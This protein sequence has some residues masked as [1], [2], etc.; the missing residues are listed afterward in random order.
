MEENMM[1]FGQM[2][3]DGN[4]EN[5]KILFLSIIGEIEGH[6]L[7]SENI[8]TT[9]YEHLLPILARAQDDKN[10]EGII[11]LIN[12]VGG[13]CSCGLALAEMIASMTKP[14]VSLI[15]GDSHSIGFP[16]SVAADYTFIAPTAT[17]ILHPVRLT[18]T[19]IG[20]PQTFDYFRLMQDRIINFLTEHT[21]ASKNV[22]EEMMLH[23][24]IMT[25]DLGTILLGEEAVKK[26]LV[27]ETG[28]IG[29]AL[30]W[31]HREIENRKKQLFK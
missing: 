9:K 12:S 15:I 24:G 28:G 30:E 29:D 8:K 23:Q 17:V 27:D 2:L 6:H 10:I 19:I 25:K 14:V 1:E 7:S 22:L 5:H 21:K 4:K 26:G 31:L 18:G 16:L 13:D 11:L 3:L 20:A